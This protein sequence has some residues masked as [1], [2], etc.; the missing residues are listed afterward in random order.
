MCK[1]FS[2]LKTTTHPSEPLEIIEMKNTVYLVN[3]NKIS[4]KETVDH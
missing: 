1:E 3:R 2:R 4:Q